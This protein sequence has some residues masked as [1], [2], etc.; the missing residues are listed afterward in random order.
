VNKSIA[1]ESPADVERIR[2]WVVVYLGVLVGEDSRSIDIDVPFSRFDLD[3]VDAVEMA[4]EFEKAFR[5][6]VGPEFFLQSAPTIRAMVPRLVELAR[7][8]ST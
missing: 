5:C 8:K 4:A 2:R 3:S 7:A 6:E 1:E